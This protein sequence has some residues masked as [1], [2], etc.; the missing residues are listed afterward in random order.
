MAGAFVA[1]ADDA[2][3]VYWNPAGIATGTIVSA[4]VDYGRDRL[5]APR[6]QIIDSKWDT[7]FNV[8]LSATAFGV[9]YFQRQ[10]Y[11][12]QADEPEVSGSPSREEVRRSVHAVDTS[13]FGVSLLQSFGNHLVVGFTPKYLHG[14]S[15]SLFDI[16]AGAM[17]WVERIR[18]GVVA[19]NLTSPEFDTDAG[20]VELEP[21]V[22]VGAAW[23][24]GWTGISRVIVSLD[25][26]VTAR[27]TPSGDRRD[28]AA[29]VETWWLQQRLGLRA[30]L[31][32]STMGEARETFA[33]GISAGVTQGILVEAH[34]VRGHGDARSWSLGA[35]MS[36]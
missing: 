32:G 15:S 16:D 19:R 8:A 34:V 27:V 1:V 10:A 30:G 12:S 2:S 13:T 24:S 28:L 4:V 26:D 14:G 35:R 29:G 5:E 23:G 3:A 33:A 17:V 7:R 6:T 36:F 25:G 11:V 9:A 20:R 21:E 18:L 22:T 31:R